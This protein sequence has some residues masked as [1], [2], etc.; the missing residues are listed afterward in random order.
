MENKE[1]PKTNLKENKMREIKIEKVVLSVG[2]VA[3]ELEK[4]VKLLE[5][6]SGGNKV[7]KMK[8]NKRIPTW[9]VR[10]GLEIGAVV[11]IRKNA[12][13][14]LKKMLIA[15]NNELRKKQISVN[16]FSFGIKEYIE[17]PGVE[18]KREIGMKG[19]DI[20][21]VFKRAGR[22]V[23]LKKIKKGK[24]PPRQTI[25]KEE[26]IKFMEDKFQTKF[27]EK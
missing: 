9:S 25:S 8:S 26:I 5:M 2:G 3:E 24:V 7:A 18:Y 13:D 20:T 27:K 23:R 12:E 16:N 10:P 14:V 22:R 21:V 4:G 17:I 15:I 19:L 6:F 11:T 1:A